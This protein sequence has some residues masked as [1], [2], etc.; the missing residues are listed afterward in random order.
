MR[1][2]GAAQRAPPTGRTAGHV[3]HDRQRAHALGGRDG[4]GDVVVVGDVAADAHDPVAEFV[5]ERDRA[6]TVAVEHRH[7]ETQSGQVPHGRGA[8]AAGPSGDD[9]RPTFELHVIPLW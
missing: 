3:H 8:Q 9:R 1:G 6:I 7:P 2:A 5:G 4:G